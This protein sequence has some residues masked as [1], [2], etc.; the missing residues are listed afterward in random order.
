[1]SAWEVIKEGFAAKKNSAAHFSFVKHH[2]KCPDT[3]C[4]SDKIKF[5]LYSRN[6]KVIFVHSKMVNSDIR[7][8]Q[9]T[10]HMVVG[11]S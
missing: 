3:K 6:E 2:K 10:C 5:D 7:P 8:S 9:Q 4:Q 11:V 1:M